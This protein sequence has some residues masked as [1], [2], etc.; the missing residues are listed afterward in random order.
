VFCCITAAM[1]D[2]RA[3]QD[4]TTLDIRRKPAS[5]QLVFGGGIHHCLGHALAQL[6]LEEALAT[7]TD[8]FGA[9]EITGPI[10]WRPDLAMIH[11]PD[12]MPLTFAQ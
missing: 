11:G 6:E 1:R 9:P 7:L 3:F 5:R 8:R 4:P 12:E 2:P 10:V